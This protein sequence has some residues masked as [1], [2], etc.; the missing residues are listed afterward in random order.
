MPLTDTAIRTL[1]PAGKSYRKSDERGLYLE[2]YPSGAKLWRFRYRFL[3]KVKRIAL[4]A[5]PD[6]S[7]AR[8]GPKEA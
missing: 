5:Y 3:D 6:V 1:K 8:S 7:L 2:I 4:G